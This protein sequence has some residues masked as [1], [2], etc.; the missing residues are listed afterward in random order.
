MNSTI[1][2]T[3]RGTVYLDMGLPPRP[4]TDVVL[5]QARLDD[6]VLRVTFTPDSRLRAELF[7][8]DGDSVS[9]LMN[10]LSCP[11]LGAR[12]LF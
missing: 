7:E 4:S 9:L 5:H 1:G 10:V 8:L 2:I 11:T 12:Y 3:A 6:G